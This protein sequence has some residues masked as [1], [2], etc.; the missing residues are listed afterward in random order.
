MW[1]YD[2][3]YYVIGSVSGNEYLP[4]QLPVM[5]TFPH[6]HSLIPLFLSPLSLS[7]SLLLPPFCHSYRVIRDGPGS[8]VVFNGPSPLLDAMYTST[9]NYITGD[10]AL[11]LSLSLDLSLSLK[12][13][14][15]NKTEYTMGEGDLCTAFQTCY[16][17]PQ[18]QYIAQ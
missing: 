4:L 14:N 12:D 7:P 9:S 10:K 3:S 1:S 5:M 16:S 15:N 2:C 6:S 13:S 17:V 11:S 8:A 18:I